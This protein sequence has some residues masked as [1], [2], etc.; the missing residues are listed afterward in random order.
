MNENHSED[1]LNRRELINQSVLSGLALAAG[2]IG[3][4]TIAK[5]QTPPPVK[6]DVKNL[7]K[8]SRKKT[9]K[10]TT[11]RGDTTSQ[12]YQQS[13]EKLKTLKQ[14]ILQIGT[15]GDGRL[16]HHLTP[17]LCRIEK[18][19]VA[20]VAT[21]YDSFARNNVE[22]LL[23][24]ASNLLNRALQ[25]RSEWDTLSINLF[26]LGIEIGQFIEYDQIHHKET[27]AGFYDQLVN[28]RTTS[29]NVDQQANDKLQYLSGL[30]DQMCADRWT[31][32]DMD[33]IAN[34]HAQIAGLENA[35]NHGP[36]IQPLTLTLA[37]YRLAI[38]FVYNM[39][40]KE[41]L[42]TNLDQSKLK[43]DNDQSKLTWETANRNFRMQ[44]TEVER[45]YEYVKLLSVQ[46]EDGVL[47][48][49]KR[50][51]PLK[52]R[53][54]NDFHEALLRMTAAAQGM[55]EIYA[56]TVPLPDNVDDPDY[57][58][59]CVVWV[60]HAINFIIKF[61][62]YDQSYVVPISIRSLYTK[63]GKV[64]Q[65]DNWEKAIEEG[66]LKF[67]LTVN[68]FSDTAFIRIKGLSVFFQL[69]EIN[70][71][72]REYI[73]NYN[74]ALSANITPPA[75]SYYNHNGNDIAVDQ[76]Y[77]PGLRLNRLGTRDFIRSP[78][79]GGTSL[80]ANLSPIGNWQIELPQ[81]KTSQI[82]KLFKINDVIL[83]LYITVNRY[84][85]M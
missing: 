58:D 41:G 16:D 52:T 22:V 82:D 27:A 70:K 31:Q 46:A 54:Q 83:D 53:F 79:V 84:A 30:F 37:Q 8:S 19:T 14:E 44:R 57:F 9:G 3:L 5:A 20:P 28:D 65:A 2:V 72:S 17:T 35:G 29:L 73:A 67:M 1:K 75:S 32:P 33:A 78:E 15:G 45:K 55:K 21:V 77:V 24:Q 74:G 25:D 39:L 6:L 60:R 10:I 62:R 51:G 63:A 42:A 56:Y 76:G 7:K 85:N 59:R 50:I 12:D 80:Y 43:V 26:S 11:P 23:D 34:L 48:Y 13:I 49:T 66:V 18:R 36:Q 69:G 61:S 47:N 64:A 4:S 68:N 38:D 81:I 71:H 40:Q